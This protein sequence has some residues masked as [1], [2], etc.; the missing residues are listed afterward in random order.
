MNNATT[1]QPISQ[2]ELDEITRKLETRMYD[3]ETKLATSEAWLAEAR[4]FL[5]RLPHDPG[6]TVTDFLARTDLAKS[7]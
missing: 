5:D 7:P 1:P 6:D 3:L 2:R 4:M